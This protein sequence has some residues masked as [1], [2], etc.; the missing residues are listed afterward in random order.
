M[1]VEKKKHDDEDSKT[2]TAAL[3]PWSRMRRPAAEASVWEDATMPLLEYTTDRR[4]VFENLESILFVE[5]RESWGNCVE[6]GGGRV[7]FLVSFFH[8]K[9]VISGAVRLKT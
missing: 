8:G 9:S 6:R 3:P 7:S 1:L 4:V 5:P 2:H